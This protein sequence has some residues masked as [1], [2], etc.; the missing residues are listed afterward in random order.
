MRTSLAYFAENAEQLDSCQAS[1]VKNVLVYAI[2]QPPW[3]LG[4][5]EAKLTRKGRGG[6]LKNQR[7]AHHPC[8]K[9]SNFWEVLEVHSD[10]GAG[11][12]HPP[13]EGVAGQQM[14]RVPNALRLD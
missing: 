10:G 7:N 5:T 3:L 4:C 8:S 2:A 12:G 14:Q 1:A 9:P 13:L 11:L 6:G